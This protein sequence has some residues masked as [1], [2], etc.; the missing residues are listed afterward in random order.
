MDLR[1]LVLAEGVL[2]LQTNANY[3]GWSFGQPPSAA[4]DE[5]LQR[6]KVVLRFR[7]DPLNDEFADLSDLECYHYWNARPG[8]DDIYYQ[9]GLI[10]SAKL[11]LMVRNMLAERPEMLANRSFMR[12]IRFR[13]N[14][15]HSPGYHL[16][17]MASALLLRA[18]FAALHCS[19]FSIGDATVAVIAPPNSG[20]TLTTMK[21]VLEKKAK[22]LSEDLAITDGEMLYACPWTSTFR[23]Y[24]DFAMNWRTKFRMRLIKVF[25]PAELL[26]PPDKFRTIDAYIPKEQIAASGRITHVAFLARR[27]GGVKT[28]SPAEANRLLF[29]LNRYEFVYMKNP[30]LVAFSYFNPEL[31]LHDL[32]DRERAILARISEQA[33]C[34]LVQS[35][36]PTRFA[37]M[38]FDEI[39]RRPAAP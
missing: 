6:C 39:G 17:D 27:D 7:V 38:I 19:A 10:G 9:R 14:N 16:T 12:Y 2:G 4:T 31:D 22:F 30:L 35:K 34:L 15:L 28:L 18:G 25:P 23:Y 26:P 11:R 21:A 32:V 29:N 13:F 33:T 8:G 36:D 20:K 1:N 37:D 24:D 5:E 3:L